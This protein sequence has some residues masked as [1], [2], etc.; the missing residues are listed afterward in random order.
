Y[1]VERHTPVADGYLSRRQTFQKYF[2][3]DELTEMVQ[4][5]TG[6][7]AVALAPGIVAAFRDKDLEQQVSFRRRSRATIYANLAIPARDPSRFLL[8]PKSRPV[9]E[10]AGEELEAI[11]RTALDLGRLPLEA[12]VGPAV[13]TALEEKG[14]TVGRALA[15]C[16]REI[17]DP[18]QLKVAADSRREDLVVHFAV[19]LFPGA[20]RYGSLP[21]SIQR[22]VRTF[23]GSLASVVEAAKAELHSLRDRA[24]LE[25]A[26]GEAAR[27]GYASYENGTLRFMAENL[28][29]LPVKA[30]IVAGCAE[31]VHQGFALLDFIEI[32][33][34]Q[35]VVRGLE[36]DM[37]ESALPRVRAS[38]EVDLARSRSRTKT[39]EG[40]VLYLKSRYLQRGH[41]GL[42][43]QTAADRKL[44]ELGIVD[45]KGNGPPADRIA[46]MLASATRA[47]AITH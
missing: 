24:A 27:S 23:F 46:A 12:E 41:P 15:A 34:E 13:R 47:G 38:V 32:G 7:R 31:I 14:I 45:A 44:L 33:P 36:C 11:W 42:G 25:E 3:Q 6:Q 10:R 22:D 8:R 16:A 28:E 40:K 26:Y 35:G 17:A 20:S 18:A 5:V 9:A 30:R 2:S 1:S 43:K 29:Q 21:A 39:F 37:V 4:R 19:T